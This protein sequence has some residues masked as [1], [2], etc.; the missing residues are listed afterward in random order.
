MTDLVFS[1]ALSGM[2]LEMVAKDLS[3][4]ASF[5]FCGKKWM[6]TRTMAMIRVRL[7]RWRNM[8]VLYRYRELVTSN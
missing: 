7:K 1:L 3:F 5:Q 4:R 2:I 6:T 8:K